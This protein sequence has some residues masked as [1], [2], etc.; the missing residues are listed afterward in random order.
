MKASSKVRMISSILDVY[1]AHPRPG[2]AVS[3]YTYHN[4]V[5]LSPKQLN[6]LEPRNYPPYPLAKKP[7]TAQPPGTYFL[8]LV[9]PHYLCCFT[10]KICQGL[11][12]QFVR[13]WGYQWWGTSGDLQ[14]I[15]AGSQIAS[16]SFGW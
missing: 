10:V 1:W 7:A 8:P 15:L 2:M 14:P 5:N 13:L 11:N 12:R 3:C 6:G 4:K 16:S 9:S